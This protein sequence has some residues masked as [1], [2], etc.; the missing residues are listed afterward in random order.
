MISGQAIPHHLHADDSQLYVSFASN[1][2]VAALNGWQSCLASVQSWM[3]SNKLK[4]NSSL[5]G[6]NNSGATVFLFPSEHFGVKLTQLTL[7]SI[8]G[9]IFD[10][11]FTFHSHLSSVCSSC[12]Y[13]IRALCGIRHYLDLVNAKLFAN[14]LVSSCLNYCNSLLHGIADTDLTKLRWVQNRLARVVIKSPPCSQCYTATF[15]W[16]VSRK[17]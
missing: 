9:V 4:L 3:S 6:R 8:L 16:L 10:N 17:I 13:H 14:A 5:L 2:S 11:N 1:N 7:L 15:P 12:F